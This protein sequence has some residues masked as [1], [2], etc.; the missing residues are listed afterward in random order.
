[1]SHGSFFQSTLPGE[2]FKRLVV[3]LQIFLRMQ[4]DEEFYFHPRADQTLRAGCPICIVGPVVE[5]KATQTM[6]RGIDRL[7]M[8]LIHIQIIGILSSNVS[9]TPT[10]AW[11]SFHLCMGIACVI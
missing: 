5:C 1:M 4:K 11:T 8:P 6:L 3:V 10:I 7:H 2:C 9:K